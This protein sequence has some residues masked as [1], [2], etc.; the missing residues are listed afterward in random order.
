MSLDAEVKK[1]RRK[2]TAHRTKAVES[3]IGS[4]FNELLHQFSDSERTQSKEH[5][6]D[7]EDTT[8]DFDNLLLLAFLSSYI[9]AAADGIPITSHVTDCVV[10]PLLAPRVAADTSA[11]G[12]NVD[13][14]LL[15][16]REAAGSGA[17]GGNVA[18]PPLA[19]KEAASTSAAREDVANEPNMSSHDLDPPKSE[20]T[21]VVEGES[22]SAALHRASAQDFIEMFNQEREND[23]SAKDFYTLPG[24]TVKFQRF[25]VPMEGLP[26]LEKI[27]LK[28]PDFMS[29]C[30]YGNAVRKV[31]FQ[32][33][34][35]LLL[36]MERMPLKSFNLHKVLEWKNVLNELQSMKFD[37]KFILGWLQATAKSCI[38]RDG[39]IKLAELAVKIAD[40]LSGRNSSKV[41]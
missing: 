7:F 34:V 41:S 25:D 26:L 8:A 33:L 17:A 39:E 28:H 31:M 36:D 1:Y 21:I 22:S 27:L 16:L 32:S 10:E 38:T 11:A 20:K 14:P 12:E 3:D 2:T 23:K 5:S 9:S 15:A 37:V 29:N 13:V 19:P 40:R 4:S 35:A 30:T 24:A 18:N 6:G